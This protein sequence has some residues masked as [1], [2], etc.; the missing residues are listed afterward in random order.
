MRT[1]DAMCGDEI[2]NTI[3]KAIEVAKQHDDQ[4]SF[5]FN[6]VAVVVAG[7]SDAEL[8]H[9]DWNRGLKGYLGENAIVGPY[10]PP[11]LSPE[12]LARDAAAEA[13]DAK[14]RADSAAKAKQE[15]DARADLLQ[16]LLA[17]A[18][19]MDVSDTA[20]W[21][22]CREKNQDAYGGR[23]IRYAEEWARLMQLS[24]QAG[25]SI[26]ECAEK[27]SRIADDDG[28][29]GYMFGAAASILMQVWRHG[30]ELKRWR[31]A[32]PY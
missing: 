20:L 24:M 30:E 13:E 9:R 31:L 15:A 14:V 23:I 4:C 18:P 2:T 5:E 7:D 21:A 19:D 3:R 6:G 25:S 29:T 11:S 28:I 16:R 26:E 12:A 27:N 22:K 17:K 32:N 10:P 8:I 1:L